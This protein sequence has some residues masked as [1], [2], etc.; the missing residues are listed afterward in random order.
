MKPLLIV[1]CKAPV[2][3][4]VKTRLFSRY[5]PEEAAEIY[6]QMA[7]AVIGR[8][9]HL[10]GNV[11]IAADYPAHPFFAAFGLPVR[12]QGEGDL[13]A[14]MDRLMRQAF[15][16]GAQAVFFI[17]TDSPHMDD[18]RLLAAAQALKDYDLVIGPVEDG[19]YDLIAMTGTYN[20]FNNVAWSSG[21][22]LEQTLAHARRLGLSCLQ[23]DTGFDID[24]PED[25]Q[26]SGWHFSSSI[27]KRPR[28][29]H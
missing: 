19:G 5:S 20:V 12:A 13:G 2:A 25:L 28:G 27:G 22:V 10:F 6:R 15:A 7:T 18:A 17:G 21:H 26:R 16:E 29:D 3:G 4:R 11:W 8:A 9:A 14:R 1:M 23:L 24:T